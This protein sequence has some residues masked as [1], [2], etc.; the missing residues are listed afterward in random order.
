LKKHLKSISE[1]LEQIENKTKLTEKHPFINKKII[2]DFKNELI[3]FRFTIEPEIEININAI[4]SSEGADNI[5]F[6]LDSN[7]EV[8]DPFTYSQII[9]IIKEGEFR[10]RHSIPPGYKDEKEKIGFQKF[11]DL[12]I[13]KQ[14]IEF[15]KVNKNPVILVMDDL[16]ED[17]W[18]LSK[19]RK[20]IKPR[21]ELIDEILEIAN[22]RFWMYSTADFIKVSKR[23]INSKIRDN[24]I[25]EINDIKY[26]EVVRI[27]DGINLSA[28]G[29]ADEPGRI[30]RLINVVKFLKKNHGKLDIEHLHDH[31]GDLTVLWMK[32]PNELEKDLVEM[33]W[34]NQN[35][36]RMNVKHKNS[37]ESWW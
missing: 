15:A 28:S 5:K 22:V 33:A 29:E 36:D 26:A 31:K 35:E 2:E 30:R 7:F 6:R 12:I 20:P 1:H 16:K 25:E 32:K 14:I 9:E 23:Y 13:W 34:E 8:G 21:E 4:R 17:W 10:Y 18:I 11:G 37:G 3:K 27:V 19:E 24:T